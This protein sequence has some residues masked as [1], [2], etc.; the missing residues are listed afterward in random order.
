MAD[1]HSSYELMLNPAG[2]GYLKWTP[3]HFRE[4]IEI[5]HLSIYALD[6]EGYGSYKFYREQKDVIADLQDL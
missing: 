3:E 1:N 2:S 5:A 4:C 6:Q